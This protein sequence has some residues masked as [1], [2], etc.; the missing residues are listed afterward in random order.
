MATN[1]SELIQI[2]HLQQFSNTRKAW[3][4]TINFCFQIQLIEFQFNPLV[5]KE[6]VAIRRLWF[7]S[8]ESDDLQPFSVAEL[9]NTRSTSGDTFGDLVIGCAMGTLNVYDVKSST[10][11]IA[12]LAGISI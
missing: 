10:K 9:T 7:D 8:I 4:V 5:G 11:S 3:F 12:N 2:V 1:Q 6:K